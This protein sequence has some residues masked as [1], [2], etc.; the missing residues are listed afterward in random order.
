MWRVHGWSPFRNKY[1]PS[2]LHYKFTNPPRWTKLACDIRQPPRAFVRG[3]PSNTVPSLQIPERQL[4]FPQHIPPHSTRHRNIVRSSQILRKG[5]PVVQK[6]HLLGPTGLPP[7]TWSCHVTR[8]VT[9]MSPA[10]FHNIYF[11]RS[12]TLLIACRSLH[13]CRWRT[14]PEHSENERPTANMGSNSWSSGCMGCC[15]DCGSCELSH[16]LK[17]L[18]PHSFWC[19]STLLGRRARGSCW[20]FARLW[21]LG[22]LCARYGERVAI[23]IARW[24]LWRGEMFT[25]YAAADQV[26]FVGIRLPWV[27]VGLS[28]TPVD[29]RF[30][31]KDCG[32][33]AWG[34]GLLTGIISGLLIRPRLCGVLERLRAMDHSRVFSSYYR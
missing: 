12:T 30:S 7:G 8:Y 5:A 16:G 32:G 25:V 28:Q 27:A 10:T 15:E 26:I 24:D 2:L 29:A 3:V 18:H 17:V 14:V 6:F 22:S 20:I 23:S 1:K 31:F 11:P 4:A 13:R 34:G 33:W 9:P 21:A 19:L